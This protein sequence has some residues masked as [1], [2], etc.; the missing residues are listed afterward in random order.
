MIIG[1][2]VKD[3]FFNLPAAQHLEAGIQSLEKHVSTPDPLRADRESPEAFLTRS[4]I[5]AATNIQRQESGLPVLIAS[6]KLNEAADRKV[7]EM[8]Q[9][10]YFA[11]VSPDG[12]QAS[13]LASSSGYE[14]IAIGENL[15]LG[16]FENDGALV[17]AWMD[18]PGHRENILNKKFRD[19]GV[20]AAR[21][22]YE[23]KTTWL[24][25]QIFG[26]SASACGA[27]D[28]DSKTRI[29]NNEKTLEGWQNELAKLKNE[30]GANSWSPRRRDE[31]N[32]RLK[33]YNDLVTKYNALVG[34][35]KNLIGQYNDQVNAFNICLN[36]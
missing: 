22:V 36:R 34:M 2:L 4:G 3:R 14:Y 11:H 9:K 17:R 16:N 32:E 25:V 13:D 5:V 35:T 29:D 6:A 21:G 24:A 7:G 28:S 19:L 31:Y 23:G 30:I 27:P 8:F 20:A 18:S 15:A 10:Q 26:L 1:V 33:E 12:R